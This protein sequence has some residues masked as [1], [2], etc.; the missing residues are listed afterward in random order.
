MS[1]ATAIEQTIRAH[2]L[3]TAEVATRLGEEQDRATFY[4]LLNGTT[5]VPRLPTVVR[6]CIALE[7]NPSDLLELAGVWSPETPG[8]ASPD[9]LRLRGAFGRVRAL[10]MDTQQRAVPLVEAVAMAWP[11]E[12]GEQSANA[13]LAG[14][15]GAPGAVGTA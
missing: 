1:L 9:D 11:P 3:T 6:L 4:R 8:Y 13:D 12:E 7:T 15:P 5:T 14:A 2:G 10:P